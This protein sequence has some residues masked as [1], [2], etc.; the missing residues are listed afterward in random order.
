MK[1][2]L[3]I[4]DSSSIHTLRWIKALQDFYKIYLFDWRL[5][6]E[7]LYDNLKNVVI[8]KQNRI[9]KYNLK[10]ASFIVSYI[11]VKKSQTIFLLTLYIRTMHLAMVF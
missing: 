10:F 6:D 5:I 9:L 1:K 4:S 8:V 3:L 7:S 11:S 2:I